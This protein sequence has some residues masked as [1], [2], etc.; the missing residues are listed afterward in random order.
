[1]ERMAALREAL[2]ALRVLNGTLTREFLARSAVGSAH[3]QEHWDIMNDFLAEAREIQRNRSAVSPVTVHN[4]PGQNTQPAQEC[5]V[6]A[7]DA[8]LAVDASQVVP[9]RLL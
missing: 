9:D 3:R 6:L 8:Q 4:L 2:G 7:M 5:L 1:M